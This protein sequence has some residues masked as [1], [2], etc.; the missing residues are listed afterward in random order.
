MLAAL[1]WECVRRRGRATGK[2][3]ACA[4]GRLGRV[5]RSARGSPRRGRGHSRS[6]PAPVPPRITVSRSP[7]R[8]HLI[9]FA[10]TA[11]F[12]PFL[13]RHAGIMGNLRDG[14]QVLVSPAVAA[15]CD[16]RGGRGARCVL[17]AAKLVALAPLGR[18][19]TR[20]AGASPFGTPATRSNATGATERRFVAA[21]HLG[22]L[23]HLPRAAYVR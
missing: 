16:R 7:Q 6:T 11:I 8:A 23:P 19:T 5:A 17:H 20:Q 15:L 21:S 22:A 2:R 18:S 4:G 14:C 3:G 9:R 13:G 12:S 1:A 10:L